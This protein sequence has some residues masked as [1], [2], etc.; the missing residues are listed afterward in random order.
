MSCVLT[1]CDKDGQ[2]EIDI[3]PALTSNCGKFLLP[4][5]L[6]GYNNLVTDSTSVVGVRVE[7]T[8][9][10]VDFAY[11][12]CAQRQVEVMAFLDYS[13][14]IPVLHAKINNVDPLEECLAFFMHTDTFDLSTSDFDLYDGILLSVHDWSDSFVLDIEE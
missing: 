6:Q 9:L 13:S 3:V 14:F 10:M 1:S 7:N 2:G 11:S 4:F 8:C 12:G 5:D